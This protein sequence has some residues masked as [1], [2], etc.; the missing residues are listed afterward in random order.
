MEMF[1]SWLPITDIDGAG[2]LFRASGRRLA[3]TDRDT[4][5][6]LVEVVAALDRDCQITR[7]GFGR[8]RCTVCG[9]TPR[10]AAAAARHQLGDRAVELLTRVHGLASEPLG[11]LAAAAA[12]RSPDR[13]DWLPR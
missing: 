13:W 2:K 12:R 8:Y 9:A 7:A 11:S 10:D 3:G 4:A 1:R 5:D 6:V